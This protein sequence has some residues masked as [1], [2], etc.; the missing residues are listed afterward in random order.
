[1][2]LQIFRRTCVLL[3]DDREEIF[4][5][6]H[7]V[8]LRAPHDDRGWGKCRALN[9]DKEGESVALFMMTGGWN[10][11]ATHDGHITQ[12]CGLERH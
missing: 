1:M 11:H 2:N 10:I 4:V 9:D 12:K 5:L 3:Q 8:A 6:D 7:Y